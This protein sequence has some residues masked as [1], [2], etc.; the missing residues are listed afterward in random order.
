MKKQCLIK[1]MKRKNHLSLD[2]CKSFLIIAILLA[3]VGC[4]TKTPLIR[5]VEKSDLTGVNRLLDEG[6]NINEP[7]T[8]KWS[9]SPLYWATYLCMEDMA[10]ALLKRGASVNVPGPY[11]GTLLLA[12]TACEDKM[13]PV[14]KI[15]I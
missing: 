10:Q 6:A 2:R 12:A 14:V 5:A 9:A 15:L 3:T 11:G 13:L 4:T 7:S 1:L 8:G